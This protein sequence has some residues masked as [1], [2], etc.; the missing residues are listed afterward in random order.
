MPSQTRGGRLDARDRLGQRRKPQLPARDRRRHRRIGPRDRGEPPAG[1]RRQ[2]AERVLRRRARRAARR[3]RGGRGSWRLAV[4]RPLEAL[5][6]SREPAPHPRLDGAERLPQR[7][8]QLGVREPLE[9]RQRDRLLLP[10]F[11]RLDAVA[12]R[13]ALRRRRSADRPARQCRQA[14]RS[15]SPRR[16]RGSGSP[17]RDRAGAAGRGSGCVRCSRA[18]SAAGSCSAA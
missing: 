10:A 13:R 18:M 8:R 12:H 11:E 7:L 9:E 15:R 4:A 5:L 2:R 17:C 16:R 14:G 3:D 1:A 6:Q